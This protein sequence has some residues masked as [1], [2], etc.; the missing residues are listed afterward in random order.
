ML[1]YRQNGEKARK[2][3]MKKII[4]GKKYDTDTAKE[5]GY[6]TN[7]EYTNDLYYYCE[8]LYRKKTG[9]FFLHG[10]GNSGTKYAT[11]LGN[12]SWAGG[13][14]IIPLTYEAAQKWAE[15]CLSADAYEEIFGEIV[16]D[17]TKCRFQLYL[18]TTAIEKAKRIASQMGVSV[19]DFVESLI[20]KN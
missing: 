20:E 6:Y 15:D 8:T 2:L 5:L 7:G 13:E 19:S 17:D 3:I 9:E 18:T 10:D 16:E 4:N 14:E 12:N 11:A 1:S